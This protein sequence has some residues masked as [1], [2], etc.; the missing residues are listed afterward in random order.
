MGEGRGGEEGGE[1]RGGE[2]GGR[3]GGS[4]HFH[5]CPPGR[6]PSQC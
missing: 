4:N 1:G 2:E 6:G 3:E 5:Q